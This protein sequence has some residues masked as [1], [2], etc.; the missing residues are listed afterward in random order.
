MNVIAATRAEALPERRLALLRQLERKLL[1]LSAWMIHNANHIRPNRDGLKVGGHQASCASVISIMAALYFECCARRTASRSSRMPGRCF[2][3]STTCSAARRRE[4]MEGLRQFGGVQPYPS[5]VKDGAGGRFLHRLGRP[6]RRDDHVLRADA[7]LCAA[8][9]AWAPRPAGGPPHRDRGRRRA[10]RGQHLRGA[11]G[12]LEAR[13]P[14][15]LVDHRLQP[16][17]PRQRGARPAVRPHRRPVPRHG[18]ERASRSNT[19]A[20]WRPRSRARAARRC[21]AGSTTAPTASIPR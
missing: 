13:R 21:A 5:R 10:R 17:K 7:G 20:S 15:F 16:P 8:A 18:L 19:A 4:K 1:W 11:A 6:R 2:T 12:R 14:R 3:R 9:R